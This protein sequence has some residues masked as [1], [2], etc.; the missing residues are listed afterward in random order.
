MRRQH[1]FNIPQSIHWGTARR[2][3]ILFARWRYWRYQ[4]ENVIFGHW[5]KGEWGILH[6]MLGPKL[7]IQ[8]QTFRRRPFVPS[9]NFCHPACITCIRFITCVTCITYTSNKFFVKNISPTFFVKY[10]TWQDMLI[11][12]I[13]VIFWLHC[14]DSDTQGHWLKQ[15]QVVWGS[16]LCLMCCTLGHSRTTLK[17]VVFYRTRVRS[18]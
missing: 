1:V 15:Q 13:I 7:F 5:L 11:D 4:W 14:W 17:F 6:P 12:Y 8:V 9:H 10:T 18:F 16:R 3:G 2:L